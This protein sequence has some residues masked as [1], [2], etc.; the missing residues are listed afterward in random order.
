MNLEKHLSTHFK[1]DSFRKGQKEIITSVLCQKDALAIMPTGGGKSLCYQLPAVVKE[2]LVIVVSPLISLMEDQVTALK[3]LGIA[4]GCLHSNQSYEEKKRLFAELKTEKSYLLYLSPERV[5]KDGFAK[6]VT[7]QNPVLFA[8]DEAHCISQW[9]HDFREDYS[10]LSLLRDLCP[11]TPILALTATATPQV[12]GDIAYRLHL[13]QPERHVYGFYRP[14]LFYQVYCCDDDEQKRQLLLQALEQTPEGRVIV[15]CGTRNATEETSEIVALH[16]NSVDFY[17]AGLNAEDRTRIQQEYDS[18]NI[19]ILCATNAF[20]MGIDHPDVRLIVHY[21]MPANVESYYQEIGRAGRDGENSS[22]LLLYS[23]KDK[24]LQ[25]YFIRQSHAPKSILNYR[26]RALDSIVQY[27]E[28]GECR[29][30]GVLTYFR[31]RQRISECGHCD[32]CLPNSARMIN[33][34]APALPKKQSK[35]RSKKP[36]KVAIETPMTVEIEQ[37]MQIIRKWRLDYANERDIPAFI[38]FSNKTLKDLAIKAPKN[39]TELF[40]VYGMGEIKV[41]Q[42]GSQ[43]LALF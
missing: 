3:K 8:I 18:G 35:T 9:G 10:K 14:N 42:F 41:E 28:G 11:N 20:G 7:S 22:C 12:A 33:Y 26:W 32:I 37:R 43:L 40:S 27:A 1:L 2:G 6:W 30:S 21:Q 39:E 4:A 38:V 36:K 19:R 29:H 13:R 25:S 15:Y 31:D 24:G 23:K 17:H 34:V 16:H 5:Q